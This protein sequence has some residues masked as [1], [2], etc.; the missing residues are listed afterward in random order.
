MIVSFR[1]KGLKK[2]WSQ[3]QAYEEGK[4]D[5]IKHIKNLDTANRNLIRDIL[6]ILDDASS[7]SELL[8]DLAPMNIHKLKEK[9]KKG[10]S[11][12][13][14]YSVWVTA[15]WRIT[16]YFNQ[17]NGDICNVELVDYLDYH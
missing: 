14:H 8:L 13:G 4:I 3:I 15:N 5:E 1:H 12:E 17:A 2:F 11:V 16:F 6:I 10:Q 9:N 7:E